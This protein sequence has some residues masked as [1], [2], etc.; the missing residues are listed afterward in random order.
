MALQKVFELTGDSNM[1][2]EGVNM[3]TGSQTVTLDCYAKIET[4]CGSKTSSVMEVSFTDGVRTF[5][6][7]YNFTPSLGNVNAFKEGYDHL[8]TLPEFVGATDV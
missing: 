8:K 5:N 4:I 7:A 1:R 6:R 2:V 3:P